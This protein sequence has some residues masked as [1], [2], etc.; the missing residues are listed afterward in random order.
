MRYLNKLAILVCILLLAIP[1]VPLYAGEP[2]DNP[3]ENFSMGVSLSAFFIV[4]IPIYIIVSRPLEEVSD[5]YDESKAARRSKA[6]DR[7]PDMEVKEIGEDEQGNP[8]IHLQDPDNPENFAILS[9]LKHKNNPTTRFQQGKIIV[10][11]PSAYGSGWLLR[12][13]TGMALAFIPAIDNMTEN[14]SALF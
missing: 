7:I 10:F 1:A 6:K 12:D 4:S 8:H 14:H 13:D 9:W 3:V 5:K 11:Q 2:S